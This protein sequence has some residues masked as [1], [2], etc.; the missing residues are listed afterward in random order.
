VPWQS[1]RLTVKGST[2]GVP[3]SHMDRLSGTTLVRWTGR[4]KV[5]DLASSVSAALRAEGLRARVEV[6]GGFVAVANQDPV[7]VSSLVRFMPGAAWVAVGHSFGAQ[8]Q[9]TREA[10]KFAAGYLKGTKTFSVRAESDGDGVAAVDLAGAVVSALLDA[11]PEAK[12]DDRRPG[13]VFR[14]L[15][16]KGRWVFGAELWT[17]PG[18]VPSGDE[19]VH[20]LVSGGKHSSVVAWMALLA[21][22]SV[23]MVHAEVGRGA[24]V[25]VARLYAELSR[26][27]DPSKLHLTLLRGGL[28]ADS[29]GQWLARSKG[30]F[31]AGT[32]APRSA[33][34]WLSERTESPLYLL[35]EEAFSESLK[36]LSLNSHDAK[37]AW[38]A[39]H[40][41]G[42]HSAVRFGGKRADM[43]EVLKAMGS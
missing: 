29:I 38:E 14:A 18:G 11:L 13:A 30:R 2:M 27:V 19:T 32:S 3:Q 43:H 1:S 39:R 24:L 33:P 5:E 25:Q 7:H 26:R 12:V 10:K 36:T 16:S 20:C 23:E 40:R 21:G 42:R 31:F 34:R 22:Y 41:S 6:L 17:G 28:P 9:M 15:Y 8:D 4:G 35:P 37:E